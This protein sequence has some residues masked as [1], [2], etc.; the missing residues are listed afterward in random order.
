MT[1]GMVDRERGCVITYSGGVHVKESDFEVLDG[2]GFKWAKQSRGD[3]APPHAYVGGDDDHSG[4]RP[5]YLGRCNVNGK[6]RIGK[7]D[8]DSRMYYTIDGQTEESNCDEP[9]EI[10]LCN[11]G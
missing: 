11:Q 2:T 7:I 5:L 9:H 10:L 3:S 8:F 6:S 1:P 4:E